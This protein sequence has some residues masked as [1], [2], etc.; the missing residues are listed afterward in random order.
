MERELFEPPEPEKG[1][2]PPLA[3]R[4]R[5]ES[6][7]EVLGQDHLIGEG[8]V[9]R[10]AIERDE[11]RSVIF[12]GPPGTGKTTLARIIAQA[13]RARFITMSAVLHGVKDLRG[14]VDAA[15]QERR[16]GRRTIL[17]ID[18]IH[19]FNKAQQDGLLPHVEDGTLT[20]I[21]ATTENPSF[22]IIPPL[23]SRS[24]VFVLE[25]LQEGHLL[26]L[27]RKALGDAA[28]GLG[29]N[30]LQAADDVLLRIAAL[31]DGDA[32]AALNILE[33][34]A[35]IVRDQ[36]RAQGGGPVSISSG[37]VAEAVQRKTLL[38]DKSGEAHYN[39]IS[40]LHKTLRS[41]DPDA[42]LYWLGRMLEGGEDPMYILRRLVRFATEDIGLA[43]PQALQVAMAAQQAFHFIG[44]PEGKLALAEAVVYLAAAPKSDAVYRAY[45]AV[46]RAIDEHPAEP[47]PLHLRNAPTRLMKDLGYGKG[48]QH[49]HE[50][51]DTVVE[52][53]GL[54]E[55]LRGHRFYRPAGRGFEAEIEK[56][57]R[58]REERLDARV[59][60]RLGVPDAPHL[61][62][63]R[64]SDPAMPG[65]RRKK[66]P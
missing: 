30:D 37:D 50:F 55:G 64:P 17:F 56:R 25:P 36:K 24:R 11:L 43:D 33:L 6:L 2:G 10:R 57:I 52:M 38:H 3:D 46:A 51:E 28:R 44:L 20:L 60:E 45:Q 15:R 41:S 58:A 34:A 13:T 16:T 31:S 48:Y 22:E 59:G 23:L 9:L 29:G 18:E 42:A 12:W 5:P 19:R 35:G 1:K 7:G 61:H 63:R 32:R 39:L 66:T 26:T 27:L 54:P 49:A 4:M 14:A 53:E 21:G 8:K 40:A 47:V 62:D 65:K